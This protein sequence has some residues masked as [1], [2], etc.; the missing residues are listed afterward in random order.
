MKPTLVVVGEDPY[1]SDV[2]AV[3]VG[4]SRGDVQGGYVSVIEAVGAAAAVDA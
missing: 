2:F 3:N 1:A 4:A